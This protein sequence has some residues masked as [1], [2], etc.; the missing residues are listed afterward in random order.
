MRKV[1]F[2]LLALALLPFAGVLGYRYAVHARH[3]LQ[4]RFAEIHA[5]V[6][7]GDD[8]PFSDGQLSDAQLA[9]RD[10]T[11]AP[12]ETPKGTLSW[13]LLAKAHFGKQG[14]EFSAD[15]KALGGKISTAKGYMFPL[16]QFGKQTHFLLSPYPSSCPFCLPAGPG[17][18][19][20]VIPTNPMEFT[21]DPISVQGRFELL[22]SGDDIKEGMFYRMRDAE[23][24]SK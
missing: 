2:I 10:N 20:E 4:Q 23:I 8:A 12:I 3:L 19:I 11:T 6:S 22:E 14:P 13:P 24:I 1:F 15:I 9:A 18:L 5:M 17:E 7:D 16:D 21:Y